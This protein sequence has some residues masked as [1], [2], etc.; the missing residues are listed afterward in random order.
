MA[1]LRAGCAFAG[2][3]QKTYL[4]GVV[5][6]F[7]FGANLQHRARPCLQYCYGLC[8]ALRIENLGHAHF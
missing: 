6:V 5:T 4:N 8:I 2:F 1:S 7:F 3:V